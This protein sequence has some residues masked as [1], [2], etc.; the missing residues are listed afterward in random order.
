MRAWLLFLLVSLWFLASG[1]VRANPIDLSGTWVLDY[2]ASDPMDDLLKAEGF[3]V[4]ER[5]LYAHVGVTLTIQ[6][7]SE[8]VVIHVQTAVVNDDEVLRTDGTQQSREVFHI[9]HVVSRT[10]WDDGGKALITLTELK[11][12]DGSPAN[13]TVKRTLADNGRSLLQHLTL[14]LHDGRT[15]KVKAVYRRA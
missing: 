7:K 14:Q 2:K 6:Q 5:R 15:I 4:I 1:A 3:S 13:G 11:A 10:H 12:G 8:Q 9:G